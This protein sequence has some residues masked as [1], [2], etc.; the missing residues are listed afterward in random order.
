MKIVPSLLLF[1]SVLCTTAFTVSPP[2]PYKIG[3]TAT[4]FKLKSVDGKMYS[5]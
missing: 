4:D 1:V 3:D 5:M 2:T